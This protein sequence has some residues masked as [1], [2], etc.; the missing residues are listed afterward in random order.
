MIPHKR[1]GVYIYIPKDVASDSAFPFKDGGDLSIHI[2][3]DKLLI[4]PAPDRRWGEERASNYRAYNRVKED[5]LAKHRGKYVAIAGGRV[6]CVADSAEEAV[7]L[8]D[9]KEAN[10]GHRIIWKVGEDEVVRVRRIGGTWLKRR[11]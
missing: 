9:E 6:L 1:G 3:G 5:F 11:R 8:S 2:R 10:P 4:E 7:R